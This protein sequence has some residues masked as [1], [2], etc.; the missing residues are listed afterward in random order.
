RTQVLVLSWFATVA[1][2]L[3]AI[4]IMLSILFRWPLDMTFNEDKTTTTYLQSIKHYDLPYS[5]IERSG[6]AKWQEKLVKDNSIQYT[7]SEDRFDAQFL[8]LSDD[9][10]HLKIRIP[11]QGGMLEWSLNERFSDCDREYCWGDVAH[12]VMRR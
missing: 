4:S 6:P 12:A 10:R 7:F 11:T 5:V 1:L 8:L 3:G 2:I 9:Q